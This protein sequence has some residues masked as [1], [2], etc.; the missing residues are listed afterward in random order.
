MNK[1]K[2]DKGKGNKTDNK[3]SRKRK[4]IIVLIIVIA[5]LILA[6]AL[7]KIIKLERSKPVSF[8][9][10]G[11]TFKKVGFLWSTNVP[12]T[13]YPEWYF[14]FNPKQ[15]EDIPTIGSMSNEFKNSPRVYI[16]FD[17]NSKNLSY[18][19]IVAA[20]L[21]LAFA[22]Y[23]NKIALPACTSN[24][25]DCANVTI[26]TCDDAE[27]E[28]KTTIFL[29]QEGPA[30]IKYGKYCITLEG[31]GADLVRASDNFMMRYYGI[32]S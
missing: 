1:K 19:A 18:D 24:T 21:S 31:K 32:I 20:D 30:L 26:I 4:I 16:T 2:E 6:V 7:Y 25:T 3:N 15:V 29:T 27:K 28:N 9:Y 14:H 11:Y 17:P 5:I 23:F 12:N 10:N 13:N 8:D 22:K